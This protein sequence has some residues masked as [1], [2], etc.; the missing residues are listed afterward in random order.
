MYILG[1]ITLKEDNYYYLEDNTHSVKLAFSQLE[2]VDPNVYYTKN[3]ILI[4]GGMQ[5]NDFFYVTEM[6]HPPPFFRKQ[7][8]FRTIEND[9]FG[10]YSK[11]SS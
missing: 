1:F 10:A 7:E 8:A 3:S 11:I 6:M 5:H 9:S 2:K 4:C